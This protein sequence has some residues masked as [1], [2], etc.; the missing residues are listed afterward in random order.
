MGP[1]G[2]RAAVVDAG[3]LIHLTEV[4]ALT[5]LRLF[6][7]LHIPNAV[8]SE[9]VGRGRVQERDLVR[10]SNVHRHALPPADV[11]R[12]VQEKGLE[13]YRLAIRSVSTSANNSIC[14]SC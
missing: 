2:L 9:T 5:L 6:E 13:P 4:G 7:T 1:R 8:W 10:L 14:P 11:A 3:P 12:F